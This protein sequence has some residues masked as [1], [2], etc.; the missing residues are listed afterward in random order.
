MTKLKI[1]DKEMYDYTNFSDTS[2][3]RLNKQ[4]REGKH[5]RYSLIKRGC[6]LEKYGISDED[7]I[8]IIETKNKFNKGQ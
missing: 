4:E 8:F 6:L 2:L 1:S 3:S 7:L 5:K